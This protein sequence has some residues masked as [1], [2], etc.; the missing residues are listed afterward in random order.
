VGL[1]AD[2]KSG[3]KSASSLYQFFIFVAAYLENTVPHT[4][5]NGNG[6]SFFTAAF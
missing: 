6:S 5:I 3:N 2:H 1:P 4:N